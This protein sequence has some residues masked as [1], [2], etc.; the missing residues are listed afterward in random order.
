MLVSLCHGSARV[1][2]SIPSRLGKGDYG[3]SGVT[4]RDGHP[5]RALG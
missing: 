5:G 3:A 4:I 2:V 1:E